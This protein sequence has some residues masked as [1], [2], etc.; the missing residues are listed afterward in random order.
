MATQQQRYSGDEL[1]ERGT[2][3]YETKIRKLVEED[4]IDRYLAIDVETG[5]FAVADQRHDAVIKLRERNP[6]AQIWGLRIGHIAAAKFGGG[7]TREK[8]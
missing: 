2:R 7:S 4:N 8:K 6:D 3:F 1:A 5:E